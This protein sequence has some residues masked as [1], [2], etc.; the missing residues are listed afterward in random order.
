MFISSGNNISSS[1]GSVYDESIYFVSVHSFGHQQ[2]QQQQRSQS[3]YVFVVVVV[4]VMILLAFVFSISCCQIIIIIFPLFQLMMFFFISQVGSWDR[5]ELA[6]KRLKI[7]PE[8]QSTFQIGTLE[9][10]T[11]R[12]TT[13]LNDPY[14][15]YTES[16]ET[17]IGN[18]RFEG[19]IID[20]VEELSKLLG[21]KYIFKLVDDGV[22]GTNEN[23]EWN[24]LIGKY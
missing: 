23:G 21:F 20:L 16:S 2:Q 24:G 9:N 19:Y 12:V 8:W 5:N 22:Y 7:K 4:V 1:G 13:I 15:M 18:E 6:Y 10:K 11:L 17:K 14:C 3:G